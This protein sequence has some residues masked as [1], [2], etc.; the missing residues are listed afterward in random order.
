L[1]NEAHGVSN[2]L[3]KA[4]DYRVKIDIS[5]IDSLNVAVASGIVL[6]ELNRK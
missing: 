5:G 2:E 6:Y 4:A 3:L 1:G